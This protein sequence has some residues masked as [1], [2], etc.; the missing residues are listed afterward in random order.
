MTERLQA[1]A[2]LLMIPGV[3]END[4]ELLVDAGITS[5]R[6]LGDQDLIQLSRRISEVVKTNI[7][8]GKVSN[9]ASPT[10]EDISSWIKMARY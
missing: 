4:S 8:Q 2:Q 7:E 10:I 6:E 9:D 5:R 3:D 1:M